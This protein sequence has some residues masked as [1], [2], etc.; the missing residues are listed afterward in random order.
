[1]KCKKFFNPIANILATNDES[2][3]GNKP[4]N[5]QDIIILVVVKFQK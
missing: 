3:R 2:R 1:M 4:R 5:L